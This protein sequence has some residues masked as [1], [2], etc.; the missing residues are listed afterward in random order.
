MARKLRVESEGA[1]DHLM[2]HG[3][4]REEIFKDDR[5]RETFIKTLGRAEEVTHRG[6]EGG[7]V[8][9]ES[10]GTPTEGTSGDEVEGSDHREVCVD[11]PAVAHREP[12]VRLELG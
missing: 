10:Q 4:R 3:D 6:L 5:G 1:I 7:E 8:G 2:S 12:I 9:V 11:C